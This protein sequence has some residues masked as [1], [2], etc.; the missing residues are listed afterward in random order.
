M[1]HRRVEPSTACLEKRRMSAMS[2]AEVGPVRL[3]RRDERH[4]EMV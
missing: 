3:I 2:A 4:A 1:T